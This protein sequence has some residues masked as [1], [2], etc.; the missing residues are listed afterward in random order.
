MG[1]KIDIEWHEDAGRLEQLY[2]QATD[3]LERTRLQ[4]M[5]QLR[6]GRSETEVAALVG[7]NARTVREWVSWYRQ[8]GLAAVRQHRHGGHGGRVA[9]LSQAQAAE[10]EQQAARGTIRTIGEAVEWV[11]KRFQVRYSYWGMRWVFRRLK[12]RRKV[13]RPVSPKASAVKQAA[14]KAAG[15]KNE[16][17]SVP[18]LKV[19]EVVWGDEMR[20]GLL[21][22]VRRVWAP[23]GV[24]IE[25]KVEVEY[26]WA[27]LNLA[28]NGVS[29]SLYWEW[30]E[31]MRADAIAP[32]VKTW[33][34][35]HGIR[36]IVWDRAPG[37]HG[38]AYAEVEVR[39]IEQPP[40]S[41]QLNPTERVIEYLRQKVEGKVYEVIAA[42]KKA[43]ERELKKLAAAPEKIRQLAGWGWIQQAVTGLA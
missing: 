3:R 40:Y 16:L 36:A 34:E 13:P 24:K 9:R 38:A 37:H 25:Q 26:E 23:K 41:P 28:V 39:R 22:Q 12:L 35:E 19:E 7:V 21:G 29:G 33:G 11:K 27:Y 31:S 5:W 32:V 18:N 1:R 43:V 30:T 4:A 8:G 6:L 42:K 17:E 15:L 20:V 10:L 2:K 14:W